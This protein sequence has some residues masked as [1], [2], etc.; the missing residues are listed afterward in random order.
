MKGNVAVWEEIGRQWKSYPYLFSPRNQAIGIVGA[1]PYRFSPQPT[2]LFDMPLDRAD[3]V[4]SNGCKGGA[5]KGDDNRLPAAKI[6]QAELALPLL[7]IYRLGC[8]QAE[9]RGFV[10]NFQQMGW[11]QGFTS[12]CRSGFPKT[13]DPQTTP[14]SAGRFCT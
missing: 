1:Y 7:T 2:Y 8:G 6:V 11:T 5:V 14:G 10:T 12:S 4:G 13:V 3:L 9:I